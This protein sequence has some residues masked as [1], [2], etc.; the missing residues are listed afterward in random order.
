MKNGF[1]LNLYYLLKILENKASE[2]DGQIISREMIEQSIDDGEAYRIVLDGKKKVG[3]V[4]IKVEGE[5]ATLIF[6]SLRHQFI[7]KASGML[8]GAKLRSYIQK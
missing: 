8:H 4:V 6:F 5:K 2:E 1:A 7:A 3:G